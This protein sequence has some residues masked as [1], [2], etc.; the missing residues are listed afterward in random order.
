MDEARDSHQEYDPT[1]S[2]PVRVWVFCR[3]CRCRLQVRMV[4][5]PTLPFSCLC[6]NRGALGDF[7]VLDR[8]ERAREVA[9]TFE[10]AYQ[11]T[12]EVLSPIMTMKKTRM[13]HSSGDFRALLEQK[14]EATPAADERHAP[15]AFE[16]E[17]EYKTTL[18]RL[19]GALDA[20]GN[21]LV[22]RHEALTEVAEFAFPR[23]HLRSASRA[24]CVR[25]CE[26]DLQQIEALIRVVRQ[27][28]PKT[29]LRFPSFRF[30]I[31]IHQ[32]AGD[33][34]EALRVAIRAKTTGMPG[35]EETIAELKAAR[36]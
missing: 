4:P 30:L 27:T 3:D 5:R 22:R 12:K 13:Y 18:G 35:F 20:A 34:N 33:L 1:V 8:E 9:E 14:S 31:K 32:E 15:A 24:F 17:A 7:D 25:A 26:A 19:M 28:A 23:R 16:S 6:G 29:R 36:G 11:A 2:E 10:V 21:D